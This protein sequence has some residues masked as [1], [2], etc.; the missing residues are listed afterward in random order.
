MPTSAI[1]FNQV[2]IALHL[3]TV[4]CEDAA[5]VPLPAGWNGELS[6]VPRKN[7]IQAG[8]S[9]AGRQAAAGLP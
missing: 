8:V 5:K 7:A 1:A 3:Y 4:Q 9:V 2:F 6:F